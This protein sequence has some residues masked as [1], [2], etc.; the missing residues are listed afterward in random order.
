MNKYFI[1]EKEGNWNRAELKVFDEEEAIKKICTFYRQLDELEYYQGIP[2]AKTLEENRYKLEI[3]PVKTDMLGNE[4]I[5]YKTGHTIIVTFKSFM[6]FGDKLA[7]ETNVKVLTTGA[8]AKA[9]LKQRL[10]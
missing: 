10:W 5:Q 4:Y 3:F 2:K 1:V 7:K 9:I 6:D 8:I